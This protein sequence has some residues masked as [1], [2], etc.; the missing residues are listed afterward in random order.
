[1]KLFRVLVGILLV[2]AVLMIVFLFLSVETRSCNPTWLRAMTVMKDLRIAIGNF[3]ADYHRFP[4]QSDKP[5]IAD[6]RAH[7]TGPF[8]DCLI[9]RNKEWNPME[10]LYID[11]PTASEGKGGYIPAKGG[12]PSQLVDP[13]G[14]PYVILL[15]TSGDNAVENPDL[16]NSDPGIARH[17]GE[18][19]P[20]TLATDVAVFS[21]GQDK[22]EGTGDD[23]VSWRTWGVAA[24]G[25]RGWPVWTKVLIVGA[26]MGVV[27][28][29][30][31]SWRAGF[32]VASR[33]AV[34]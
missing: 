9:S 33:P 18:S 31:Y 4:G 27:V 12:I 29:L 26:A 11:L 22:V 25:S 20:P 17:L 2:C 15:D 5:H 6:L 13:W 32:R 28:V 24:A 1:M 8:I 30:F 10:A 3:Q 7:S 21:L 34:P 23:I 19:P 16:K 14:S